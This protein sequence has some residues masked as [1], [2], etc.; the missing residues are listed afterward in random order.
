M[1]ARCISLVFTANCSKLHIQFHWS[2]LARLGYEIRHISVLLFLKSLK[3]TVFS[4]FSRFHKP[5]SWNRYWNPTKTLQDLWDLTFWHGNQ[6][7]YWILLKNSKNTTFLTWNRQFWHF[8]QVNADFYMRG[9]KT[10][11]Q[12]DMPGRPWGMPGRGRKRC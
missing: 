2:V 11:R 8:W 9:L 10:A 5:L 3:I 4:V 6:W 1:C 7:F 12:P